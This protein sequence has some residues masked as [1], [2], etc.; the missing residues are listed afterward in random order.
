MLGTDNISTMFR[1]REKGVLYLVLVIIFLLQNFKIPIN[2]NMP[3]IIN[4][5]GKA[6]QNSNSSRVIRIR[7]VGKEDIFVW[8]L[9][10]APPP[11]TSKY[12]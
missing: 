12:R 7:V 8:E 10:F 9:V 6:I 1:I 4:K 11:E 2:S 3:E 5:P